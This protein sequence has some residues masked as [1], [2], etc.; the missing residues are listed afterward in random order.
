MVFA[1]AA[2]T[3]TVHESLDDARTVM[4]EGVHDVR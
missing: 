2:G 1:M 3:G 4:T